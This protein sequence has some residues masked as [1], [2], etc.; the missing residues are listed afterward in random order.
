[1]YAINPKQNRYGEILC[2]VKKYEERKRIFISNRVDIPYVKAIINGNVGVCK[3]LL[4]QHILNML[5]L[6]ENM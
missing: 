2:D 6:E 5:K 4:E 1:M 3:Y